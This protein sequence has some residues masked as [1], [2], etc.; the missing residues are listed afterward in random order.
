LTSLGAIGESA[1]APTRSDYTPSIG[2]VI[3]EQ[4]EALE[5]YPSQYP[6]TLHFHPDIQQPVLG[7][8]PATIQDD[9]DPFD[10]SGCVNFDM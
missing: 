3:A 8:N 4:Q 10:L 7:F 6:Y 2:A 1:N 9:F 5:A